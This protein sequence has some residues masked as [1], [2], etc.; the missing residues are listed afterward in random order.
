MAFY[1]YTVG[2]KHF[3]KEHCKIDKKQTEVKV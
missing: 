1:L 2:K 3:A